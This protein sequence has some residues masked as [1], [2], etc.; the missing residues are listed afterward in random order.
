MSEAVGRLLGEGRVA[1]VREFGARVVKLYRRPEAKPVAFREAAIHAV[2]ESLGLPVP[3]VWGVRAFGARWGIVFDRAEGAP[4]ADRMRAEPEAVP[5]HLAALARLHAR[6]L[7]HPAD[8]LRDLKWHLRT[9]I[10]RAKTLDDEARRALLQGLDAM[11]SGARLCHGDF[12]PSNVLGEPS[13]PA[14]IDWADACRGDPAADFCRSYLL[15]RLHAAAL[16]APYLGACCEAGGVQRG[17]IL[18]WL[19]Y[20]AAARLAE[21]VAAEVP[22]LTALIADGAA[23]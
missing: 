11:P 7:A 21:D 9:N 10:Q 6:I 22:A 20:V 3:A 23:Q 16:A 14:V 18:A 12:H 1:E 17:A 13:R 8:Q 5:G 15:L 4:F 19:P 2:V